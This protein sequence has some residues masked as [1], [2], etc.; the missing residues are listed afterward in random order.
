MNP[1]SLVNPLIDT[2]NR[3][4][5]F[6]STACRPFGMVNL[7]PDTVPDGPWTGG[8]RYNVPFVSWFAH[9]HP[10]QMAGIPVLPTTGRMRGPEGSAEYR[11]H[12]SHRTEIAEPGYHRLELDR[13]GI[14]AELTA[15]VRV[16]FHRYTF[17]AN[18]TAYLLFDLGAEIGPAEIDEFVFERVTNLRYTG[19][20]VDA[21]TM[22]RPK[23]VRI[24][25]ALELDTP[26]DFHGGWNNDGDEQTGDV[27]GRD[28]GAYIKLTVVAGQSL[29]MKL[30]IS[31][32][33]IEGAIKN[34]EAEL[35]HWDFDAVRK[36][37]FDEWNEALSV[38][39]VEGGTREQQVKFYTDVYHALCG[40]R[41]VCDVD[42]SYIDNTDAA[43]TDSPRVAHQSKIRT[44]P[45]SEDRPNEPVYEHHNTDAFWGS[46]WTINV[47]WP[48]IYPKATWNF[49]NT[50]L[51]VYRNGGLIP[52]GMAGGNYTFVMVGAGSTGLFVSAALK[53][54]GQYDLEEVYAG[55]KKNHEPGGLMSKSGYEHLSCVGGGLEYYIDRGYIPEGI[56]ADGIHRDG[57]G[58]TQD[59]AFYDWC[60]AQLARKLGHAK[61]YSRYIQR[62]R[63]YRNVYNSENG[64]VQP[65]DFNGDFISEFNPFSKLGF[66]EANGWQSLWNVP[67]DVMGLADLMGGADRFISRL[68]EQF[69]LASEFDFVAPEKHSD[70]YINYGNQ[71]STHMAHLFNYVGAPWLT[72]KWVHEVMQAAKSDITPFEGYGGDEDQGLMGSLNALMAIGLFSMR[73]GC[74]EDPVYEITTPIFDRTVIHLDPEYYP[75]GDTFVIEATG[76]GKRYI[77]SAELNG[78]PLF[79]CWFRHSDLSSGGTLRLVL[80]DEPNKSWGSNPE[81]LPP[82][83]SR[84]T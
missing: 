11:S 23:P 4:Y 25:F 70:V 80:G 18:D 52:R 49:C 24:Y 63:S 38:I 77:Q 43:Y 79:R 48:L 37:A 28:G 64:F 83:M 54:I 31:Y 26:P 65:R 14:I 9:I 72:Q 61:D 81:E 73:G 39:E 1:A 34:L 16:G 76:A 13:Y 30:A 58:M 42:G 17:H 66:V 21:P 62:A 78:R 3:R 46:Q 67:H 8:Y 29:L 44:V 60:L 32:T 40:R 33:G 69:E 50:F 35:P 5:F 45:S 68:N 6:L 41:R 27:S 15:T 53:G 82:S 74:D 47:L 55:L 36:D 56:E 22:R 75:G 19:Y 10:W 7:S 57:A 71:P 12:F 2:A 51:D 84:E 59:Y 20:V